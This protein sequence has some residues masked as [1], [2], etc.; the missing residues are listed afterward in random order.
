MPASI[1]AGT[2]NQTPTLKL[3]VEIDVDSTPPN[4]AT[5]IRQTR[6][7]R[8]ALVKL[9]GSSAHVNFI[10]VLVNPTRGRLGLHSIRSNSGPIELQDATGAGFQDLE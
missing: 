4:P 2:L 7:R 6:A 5:T 9:N 1:G 8:H 10:A 3:R